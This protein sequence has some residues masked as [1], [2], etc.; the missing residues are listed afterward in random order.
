[1]KPVGT[2]WKRGLFITGG[3]LLACGNWPIV[4]LVNRLH[5]TVFGLP[6]FVWSMFLLNVTVAA[7]LVIA[8]RKVD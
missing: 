3:V 6:P 5:P 2:R 4:I 1:M 7:L 8:Y